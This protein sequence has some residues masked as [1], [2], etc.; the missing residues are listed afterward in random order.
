[1]DSIAATTNMVFHGWVNFDPSY[2][3]ASTKSIMRVMNP[4]QGVHS[5]HRIKWTLLPNMG[6]TITGTGKHTIM[7]A[8]IMAM[9]CVTIPP[10]NI[11]E[12]CVGR[13][14][15]MDLV[16]LP[17]RLPAPLNDETGE[18]EDSEDEDGVDNSLMFISHSSG[19]CFVTTAV[20]KMDKFTR[21]AFRSAPV[22]HCIEPSGTIQ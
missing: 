7:A 20:V 13:P 1:M 21:A 6:S 11:P 4:A 10:A 15:S 14:N 19:M 17:R 18:E 3:G 2:W 5:H 16:L 22:Y 8:V 9:N 12:T